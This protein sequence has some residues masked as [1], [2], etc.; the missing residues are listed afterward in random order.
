MRRLLHTIL[1]MTP[2]AQRPPRQGR[3]LTSQL[4]V[5]LTPAWS[6]LMLLLPDRAQLVHAPPYSKLTKSA[7]DLIAA[8]CAAFLLESPELEP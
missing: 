6:H 3:E 1:I 7:Q 2:W 8:A 4:Q 5:P